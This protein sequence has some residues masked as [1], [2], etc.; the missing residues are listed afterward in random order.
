[1][2]L[3]VF[4]RIVAT[5]LQD[6]VAPYIVDFDVKNLNIGVWKVGKRLS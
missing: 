3:P 1:M 6:Y 5:A 4:E 2:V